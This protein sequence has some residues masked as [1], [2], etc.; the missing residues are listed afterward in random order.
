VAA[1]NRDV[2]TWDELCVA[3]GA[4]SSDCTVLLLL[5]VSM[6]HFLGYRA[7]ANTISEKE[8]VINTNGKVF[9]HKHAS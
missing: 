6:L 5:A 7:T 4:A 1:L 9:R 3:T 8:N 2:L